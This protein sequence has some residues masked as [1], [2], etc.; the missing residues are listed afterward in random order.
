[1]GKKWLEDQDA[2]IHAREQR[3]HL[4]KLGGSIYS[5]KRWRQEFRNIPR[6]R[7]ASVEVIKSMIRTIPICRASLDDINKALRTKPS[8]TLEEARRRLP[9]QVKEFAHL[10]TYELDANK[11]PPNR[12]TLDDAISL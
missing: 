4:G 3:L 9:D 7:I 12:G 11:L 5:V 8:V 1:M 2:T 6:P 10:F